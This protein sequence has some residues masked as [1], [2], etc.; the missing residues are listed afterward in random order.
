[1]AIGDDVFYN[2]VKRVSFFLGKAKK[3]FENIERGIF[4]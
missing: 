4:P 2:E 3:I 1:V